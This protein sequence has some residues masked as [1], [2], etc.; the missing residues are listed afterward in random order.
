MTPRPLIYPPGALSWR[1]LRY[2]RIR[3]R[4]LSGLVTLAAFAVFLLPM[5]ID[6]F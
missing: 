1:R 3:Q 5:F 4:V 6:L 2:E